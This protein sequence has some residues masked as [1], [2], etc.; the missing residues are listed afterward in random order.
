MDSLPLDLKLTLGKNF[1]SFLFRDTL[2]LFQSS[3][4]GVCN[5][6]DSVEASLH[7]KLDISFGEAIDSLALC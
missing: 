5:R 1:G 3:S 6:L 2:D 7:D 4:W